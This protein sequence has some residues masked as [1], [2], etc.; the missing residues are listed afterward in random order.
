MAAY[1]HQLFQAL[2]LLEAIKCIVPLHAAFI[3]PDNDQPELTHVHILAHKYRVL[4][5]IDEDG[6]LT[7]VIGSGD[8]PG[9]CKEFSFS[10]NNIVGWT[11]LNYD[12]ID[13]PTPPSTKLIGSFLHM[14]KQKRL[15]SDFFHKMN[16][17]VHLSEPL[18]HSSTRT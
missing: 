6:L 17:H 5:T 3:V 7:T 16:E 11:S 12:K 4:L 14:I 10:E 8:E 1:V 15:P 13:C 18:G 2:R 9:D